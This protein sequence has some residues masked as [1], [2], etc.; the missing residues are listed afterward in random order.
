MENLLHV[1]RLV[2]RSESA[3]FD[4]CADPVFE[5]QAPL[6]DVLGASLESY[7]GSATTRRNGSSRPS[8]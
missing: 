7:V 5:V 4:I 1:C 6:V 2:L 3:D 8:R